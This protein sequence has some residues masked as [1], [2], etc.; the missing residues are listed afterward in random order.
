MPAKKKAAK[1]KVTRAKK[2]KKLKLKREKAAR[3]P[4]G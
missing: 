3:H 4:V 1:R 2:G